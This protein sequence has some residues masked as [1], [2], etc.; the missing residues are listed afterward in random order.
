M[1]I[2]YQMEHVK[3]ATNQIV[4]FVIQMV[5]F[6]NTVEMDNIYQMEHVSYAMT[7]VADLVTQLVKFANNVI[8][9]M[10]CFQMYNVSYAMMK[11]VKFAIIQMV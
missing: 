10:V 2:M 8:Q 7:L 1:S 5:K 11:I 3:D 4:G 9:D 6:A